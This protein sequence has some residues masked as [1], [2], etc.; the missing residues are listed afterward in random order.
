VRAPRWQFLI[1]AVVAILLL[2]LS[3]RGVDLAGLVTALKEANYWLLIPASALTLLAFYIRAVRWGILLRSVK[4]ISNGSLFS[5]TMIGF[6]AN[7]LLPARLGELVRA[8]AIWRQEQISRSAA[9]ATVVV[10]RVVDVFSLLFFFGL[11]LLLHPFPEEARRGGYLALGLN[12]IL[13]ILLLLAERNPQRVAAIGA[14]LSERSPQRIQGRVKSLVENFVTGLGV[15]RQGGA[16]LQVA[17]YSLLLYAVT[18][19]GLHAC[20]MA[21]DFSTP[22]YTALVLLVTTT[23]GFIVAP[24]PGY[25]GSIQVA[26]VWSLA[27]FGVPRSEAFSFSLFYHVTQFVPITVV[28]LW[29]LA[30]QGLSLNQVAGAAGKEVNETVQC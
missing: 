4:V 17:L 23:L 18:L 24:T 22:W 7:N 11:S 25:V 21:F 29:F 20:L 8:W 14:W 13:L 15:L 30:R 28:G 5:A 6:A 3:L 16:I 27:L 2:A 26:C 10:E 9:F 12:V 1:G 19:L